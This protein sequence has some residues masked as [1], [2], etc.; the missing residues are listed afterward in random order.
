[1]RQLLI[2]LCA[3][4]IPIGV[5][6]LDYRDQS[7][8]Y[9]DAP[10]QPAEAAGISVLTSIRAVQGNPDGTFQPRRTLN[11]AEFIKIALSSHPNI[12]I[13]RSDAT[14][15]FPD[16]SEKDWFS[17]YVCLAKKRGIVSGYLDG[18]F[19]PENPVNYVEALK[20]LGELYDYTA[21]AEPGAPWYEIYVQAAKNHKT[22]LPISLTY[23]RYLTRGQMARLASAFRAE[24]EDEIEFYRRAERGEHVVVPEDEPDP[25][26][27]EQPPEPPPPPPPPPQEESTVP[28]G[29]SFLMV[30][31]R[32]PIADF[33]LFTRENQVELR[34]VKVIMEK[35]ARTFSG[36]YLHTEDGTEIAELKLDVYDRDN[37][38]WI[39]E[40]DP[41]ESDFILPER[42]GTTF[43]V[44]ARIRR[45][46]ERGFSEEWVEVKKMFVMVG[47]SDDPT[48]QYQIVP[49]GAHYPAHQTVQARITRV[50]SLLN[51]EESL[52]QE[53]EKHLA[54]FL[55]EAEA[56][57]VSNFR[58]R[59]LRFW[60]HSTP[61]IDVSN[62][63][64]RAEGTER[65]HACSTEETDSQELTVVNCLAIPEELGELEVL[66]LYGDTDL[67]QASPGDTLQIN[68]EV[69][70]ALNESGDVR[71][72]DGSADF[73]WIE[74]PAPIVEGRLWR[75]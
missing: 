53:T 38:T 14:R 10:F 57:P 52:E 43:V 67:S 36:V 42:S 64:L 31:E 73:Q 13:S 3:L 22:I 17:K 11:R 70:G 9:L 30:G 62:W 25:P 29:S 4:L 15:C 6:A 23:D 40:L 48:T 2:T 49:S 63:E 35:E 56:D 60:A 19:R 27:E 39:V 72:T 61:E 12:I 69:P 34:I 18:Q 65:R 44:E 46:R 32:Y 58:V 8:M 33:Q 55:F 75:Y 24:Y 68:L 54:S 45:I 7:L 1:M 59:H 66:D 47:E 74:M 71:W 20:I 28:V 21:Y 50:E 37:K 5:Q 26:E 16:V 51:G 41:G